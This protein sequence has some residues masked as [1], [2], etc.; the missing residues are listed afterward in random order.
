MV[1]NTSRAT[2]LE[3]T[4]GNLYGKENLGAARRV[5]SQLNR[6]NKEIQTD[7][8]NI[9]DSVIIGGSVYGTSTVIKKTVGGER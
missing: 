7:K 6:V 2:E 4:Y 5:G 1:K 8:P 3:K 9:K